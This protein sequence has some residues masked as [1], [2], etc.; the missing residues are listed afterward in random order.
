MKVR[1]ITADA[2]I[3][4]FRV[5]QTIETTYTQLPDIDSLATLVI[6]ARRDPPAVKTT[7]SVNG[8]P[9]TVTIIVDNEI[10]MNA[11][12]DWTRTAPDDVP[13]DWTANA[14]R[15]V[16]DMSLVAPLSASQVAAVAKRAG[17]DTINGSPVAHLQTNTEQMV[18]LLKEDFDVRQ[19]NPGPAEA[20]D[21]VSPDTYINY[22]QA[23]LWVEPS[24]GFVLRERTIV[25][26]AEERLHGQATVTGPATFTTTREFYDFNA[27]LDIA[28][29][30][31]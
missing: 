28:N 4:S 7:Q 3:R 26:Y 27:A 30:V 25:E 1:S 15:E 6:E 13:N 23:D 5:R 22:Y 20:A 2:N 24:T 18:R 8:Q 9:E 12:G 29:P 16:G 31:E 17:D 14:F 19:A 10:W 21:P 11:A